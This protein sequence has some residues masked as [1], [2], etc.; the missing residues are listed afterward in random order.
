ML[1]NWQHLKKLSK[2]QTPED[3]K[4]FE[5]TIGQLVAKKNPQ[6]LDDLLDLFDDDCQYP[7]VMYGL[8]HAVEYYPDEIYVKTLLCKMEKGIKQF[9]FW[10]TG[11]ISAVFNS[12][13]CLQIF[14]Q[15]MHLAPKESLLKLFDIMEKESP[16]HQDLI[17]ELRQELENNV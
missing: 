17:K 12:K 1:E 13:N 9:P 10:Y 5:S 16:H 6:I 14:L 3:I 8:V 15:N 4:E 11:L 7:E 2:M